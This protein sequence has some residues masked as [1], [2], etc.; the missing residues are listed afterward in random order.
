M[1][2]SFVHP[3]SMMCSPSDASTSPP[4]ALLPSPFSDALLLGCLP[5]YSGRP[6]A[7]RTITPNF[8]WQVMTDL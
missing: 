8:Y 5:R 2:V 6:L 3:M 7:Q 1:V 4:T